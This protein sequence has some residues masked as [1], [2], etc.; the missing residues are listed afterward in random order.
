M[1]LSILLVMAMAAISSCKQSGNT[2]Q[3]HYPSKSYQ[4][5]T[6]DFAKLPNIKR[7]YVPIYSHIY[8]ISGEKNI[9][10]TATLSVRNPNSS[11]NIYINKATYRGS[12]GNVLKEYILKTI[13]VKPLCG[14]ELVVEDR[15]DKGGAGA[16]FTIEYGHQA[17][18]N[19]P[20]IQAVM[21]GS[22]GQQGISFTTSATD[23]R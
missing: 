17:V 11:G 20:I 6:I 16:S 19:P 1:R 4:A 23:L 2:E 3:K 21:I 7:C 15:E 5:A 8:H 10:L 12:D 14:I 18:K 22:S 9:L 13:V